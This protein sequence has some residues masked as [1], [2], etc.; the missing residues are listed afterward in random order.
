MQT[1]TV[2]LDSP[3]LYAG[4]AGTEIEGSFIELTEPT[5]KVSHLCCEIEGLI[6]TGLIA[7]SKALDEAT[8]EAAKAQNAET[9]EK[10]DADAVLAIMT[11]GGVDMKK[12]V[13]TF[14]ELFRV[15]GMMGGE[16][17]LTVPMMDRM[18]HKD[19]RKMIG[20]YAAV[21]IMS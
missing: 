6:Q 15:V 13:L 2:E 11:G 5:G 16:K 14:R 7:M 17:A 9:D 1:I 8:I 3:I 4:G 19:F 10:P 21:F 18:S 12:V 20:E